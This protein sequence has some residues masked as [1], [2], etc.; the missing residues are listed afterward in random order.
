MRLIY[1][2][3]VGG[4][5][6]LLLYL[7]AEILVSLRIIFSPQTYHDGQKFY[8]DCFNRH[9]AL[10]SL[11]ASFTCFLVAVVVTVAFVEPNNT[12]NY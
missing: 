8:S 5:L 2:K 10:E 3:V 7:E 12:R 9:R 4:L 11:P 6:L 1:I